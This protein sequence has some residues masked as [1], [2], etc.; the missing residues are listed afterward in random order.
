M[1]Y[2][3]PHFSY[4]EAKGIL[5][6]LK[7]LFNIYAL[8]LCIV[9]IFNTIL[10][11]TYGLY[12]LTT[13]LLTCTAFI[14]YLVL[15]KAIYY[16]LT[17]MYI[18]YALFSV[19]I[20]YVS[21]YVGIKSGID[22]YYVSLILCI[23]YSV[24]LKLQSRKMMPIFIFIC[25]EL[26]INFCTD[27]RLF[28]N[29]SLPQGLQSKIFKISILFNILNT[30]ISTILMLNIKNFVLKLYKTK[31]KTESKLQEFVNKNNVSPDD[32]Y[33]LNN[34][35]KEN[36]SLFFLKFSQAF[37]SFIQKIKKNYPSLT[38][39]EILVCA[40]LKLNY[41]TKEIAI[42]SNS[43]VRC[44]EN[45]KYRIRKKIELESKEDLALFISNF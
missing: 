29:R 41:S 32:L 25:I 28:Y 13:I 27:H 30:I 16:S 20:F 42:Y 33:D 19:I 35:A 14:L 40:Y 38:H 10:V 11:Y 43:S 17:F 37:P 34:L 44:I 18:A 22:L 12:F 39:N 21:S 6:R 23:P 45:K 15:S 3:S 8:S 9:F 7:R 5:I 1:H 26:L 4:H 24:N 36:S 31:I 2:R